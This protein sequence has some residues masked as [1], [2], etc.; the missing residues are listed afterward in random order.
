M[1]I[2]FNEIVRALGYLLIAGVALFAWKMARDN[3]KGGKFKSVLWKGFL[4]CAGI[5]FFASI[6][7]GNPTCEQYSDPV[8]GGCDQYANDSFEPTTEQRVASFAYFMTLLFLPV[9]I[10]AFNGNK[11]KN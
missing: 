2:I 1:T 8:Y 3:A 6:T 4:W 7:L 5:A 10:G 9:T 11:E